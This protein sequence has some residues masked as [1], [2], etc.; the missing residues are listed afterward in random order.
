[1]TRQRASPEAA[2]A[3]LPLNSDE[4]AFIVRKSAALVEPGCIVDPE[5]PQPIEL[6]DHIRSNR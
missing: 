4:A 2:V 6:A 5:D 1:M 3:T